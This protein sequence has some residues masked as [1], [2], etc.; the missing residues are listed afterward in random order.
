[1][2]KTREEI[3][4]DLRDFITDTDRQPDADVSEGTVYRDIST[5]YIA[6]KLSELS[7]DVEDSYNYTSLKF[8]DIISDDGMSRLALNY[9]TT[10]DPATI[11]SGTVRFTRNSAPTGTINIPTGT[12][13]QTRLTQTSSRVKFVTTEDISFTIDTPM[14]SYT[15]K[16]H[17][18][19]T[20][21]AIEAGSAGN[22]GKG[23]IVLF[24]NN[25]DGVDSVEN[26]TATSGGTDQESNTSLALKSLQAIETKNDGTRIGYREALEEYDSRITDVSVVVS[27][28]PEMIRDL[29]G[30][31]I[32]L[33]VNGFEDTLFSYNAFYNPGLDYIWI[34]QAYRPTTRISSLIGTT[35]SVTYIENTDWLF[36]KNTNLAFG[37]SYKSFD[38]IR[39]IDEGNTPFAG[40]QLT[41]SGVY[42]G[43][44]RGAQDYI[45]SPTRRF[46]TADQLVKE[47]TRIGI[48]IDTNIL[49]YSGFDRDSLKA[50]LENSLINGITAYQAS[51][52]V[53]QAD[54]VKLLYDS[55][56]GVD[57]VFLPF[58]FL[59]K[60]GESK[61]SDIIIDRNEFA[62]ID[63]LTITVL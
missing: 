24:E 13:V 63:G 12:V 59:C 8:A 58:N 61:T 36:E 44:V 20:V 53:E 3:S 45:D 9:F 50:T 30:G 21:D 43:V 31:A 40:E 19:A 16:W 34:D 56:T 38:V 25:I 2:A 51:E 32:D 52:D 23:S 37:K 49:A 14:D 47:M 15:R 7:S 1:M 60:T 41:I 5:E 26:T 6:N 10:R 11:A 62:R 54:L 28:D 33:Y 27:P 22:V 55:S 18:F 29:Y 35:T 57:R 39:W 17:V 46:V 4:E 48:Q 42:N